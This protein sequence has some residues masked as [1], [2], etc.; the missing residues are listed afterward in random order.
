MQKCWM[1][2]KVKRWWSGKCWKE[3]KREWWWSEKML[4][5]SWDRS[6][7]RLPFRSRV[8]LGILCTYQS[9]KGNS[10]YCS[11]TSH[12]QKREFTFEQIQEQFTNCLSKLFESLLV[13]AHFVRFFCVWKAF[14]I[15]SQVLGIRYF[16]KSCASYNHHINMDLS[17]EFNLKYKVLGIFWSH[18]LHIAVILI[19]FCLLHSTTSI[20]Y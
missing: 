3:A 2:A 1:E 10:C 4:K 9:Q 6:C 11:N 14:C 5:E 17:F 7:C 8:P 18:A 15:Q 12:S 20:R 13:F 19:W 16:L